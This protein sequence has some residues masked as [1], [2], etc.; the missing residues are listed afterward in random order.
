[1]VCIDW[2]FYWTFSIWLIWF[3]LQ[4]LHGGRFWFNFRYF[5]FLG[6][7]FEFVLVFSKSFIVIT[8][9]ICRYL[10]PLSDLLMTQ[11]SGLYA[12]G[13]FF[14]IWKFHNVQ[15][16]RTLLPV[17]ES[18]IKFYIKFSLALIG[19]IGGLGLM[20]VY[21][22]QGN[23]LSNFLNQHFAGGIEHEKVTAQSSWVI[24]VWAF[25]IFKWA[26]ACLNHL[27]HYHQ[28]TGTTRGFESVQDS[29]FKL[30]VNKLFILRMSSSI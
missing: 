18:R 15:D 13:L 11:F 7:D 22:I 4:E 24:A 30:F 19:T 12:L 21:L 14:D 16:G 27:F 9:C 3:S 10:I 25:M 6:S 5:N 1:M 8:R 20:I 26:F 28:I 17:Q 29:L 2:I 23:F